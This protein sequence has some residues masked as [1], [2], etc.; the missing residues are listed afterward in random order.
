MDKAPEIQG[1]TFDLDFNLTT[2]GLSVQD[3]A[4]SVLLNNS[5]G[6]QV[7]SIP[8]MFM[9]DS[10]GSPESLEPAR[11]EDIALNLSSQGGLTLTASA[12]ADWLL[13]PARV[14]P[15]TI[16]PT[17]INDRRPNLDTFVQSNISG[18]QSASAELKS[19]YYTGAEGTFTAQSLLKFDLGDIPSGST[20][21]AATLQL[22]ENHSYS[23]NARTVEIRR[24]DGSWGSSVNWSTK[25]PLAANIAASA[26][27]AYG[28]GSSCPGQR[29]NFNVQSVVDYW[30]NTAA[31]NY[32]FGVKAANESDTYGWKKWASD[33]ATHTPWLDVT[34]T[35]VDTTGPGAPAITSTSHALD[36]WSCDTTADFSWS[37][38]SD[39][40][41]IAGY[42]YALDQSSSTSGSS[43]M[44]T[45]NSLSNLNAA[46]P[47]DWWFHV[48]AKD[49]AGNWG[50]SKDHRFKID[51][52]T[53]TYQSLSSTTHSSGVWGPPSGR[54]DFSYSDPESSISNYSYLIDSG[55]TTTDPGNSGQGSSSFM[56]FGPLGTGD[57]TFHVKGK[58]GAGCWSTDI[59]HYGLKIDATNPPAPTVASTSHPVPGTAYNNNDVSLSWSSTDSQSGTVA[60]SYAF[61]QSPTIS[62][63]TQSEGSGTSTTYNDR[64]NGTWYFHVRAKDAVGN[65][66]STRDFQVVINVDDTP[67]SAPGITA[68]SHALD[69]WSCDTTADFTW[70]T[71]SDPSGIA[72]YWYS[73]DQSATTT[74]SP[75]VLTTGNSANNLNAASTGDWWFHV[76]AKDG[77]GNWSSITNHHFKVD[78]T[79][80]TKVNVSSPTHPSGGWGPASGSIDFQ[81]TDP[82]SGIA[83]YS[84]LLDSGVTTTDPGNTSQGA[85]TST[86]FGPLTTGDYTFHVKARNGAGCWSS[87]TQITHYGVKVD[88]TA[89]GTPVVSSSTHPVQGNTY[90]LNDASFSWTA[91]DLHSGVGGYS[92]ELNQSDISTPD[93]T[94]EGAASSKS[95]ADVAD[96]TWWFHVRARDN[97]GNWGPAQHF[98]V[99]IDTPA[100]HLAVAMAGPTTQTGSDGDPIV[101]DGDQLV[102]SGFVSEGVGG[103]PDSTAMV[104]ACDVV[105]LDETASAE[106][107]RLPVPLTNCRNVGGTIVGSVAVGSFSVQNGTAVIEIVAERTIGGVTKSS[108]AVRS[109]PIEIDNTVP[110][111]TDAVLKCGISIDMSCDTSTRARIDFSE[112]V[113]G[114]FGAE[115]FSVTAPNQVLTVTSDC[116][117]ETYCDRAEVV[118]ALPLMGTVTY[119]Y[120]TSTSKLRPKDGA[121]HYLAPASLPV[122]KANGSSACPPA[123]SEPVHPDDA[124]LNLDLPC[125]SAIGGNNPRPAGI[126]VLTI[127]TADGLEPGTRSAKIARR[128]NK[129]RSKSATAGRKDGIA[130]PP[131][132]I[133]LQEADSDDRVAVKHALN[134]E[135]GSVLYRTATGDPAIIDPGASPTCVDDAM[136]TEAILYRARKQGDGKID[137]NGLV[138]TATDSIVTGV[139]INCEGAAVETYVDESGQT[140]LCPKHDRKKHWLA[141]FE[142]PSTGYTF[143]VGSVHFLPTSCL[144]PGWSEDQHDEEVRS[145]SQTIASRLDT[146]GAGKHAL[147][148]GGD[149]SIRRCKAPIQKNEG[150]D[151]T[152]GS[153][154]GN[155]EWWKGMNTSGWTDVIRNLWGT[156]LRHQYLDGN[157]GFTNDTP[158]Y[159][160]KRLD[161]LWTKLATPLRASHDLSCGV[162]ER[163]FEH[164][165]QNSTR[166]ARERYAD[167]RLLWTILNG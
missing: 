40:S 29:V 37:T 131:D 58:N 117:L 64:A 98:S 84:H 25:P 149:F 20:I 136:S 26:N 39:P 57:H 91:T 108:V 161:Y 158:N 133:I 23:C 165:C 55:S 132:V 97:V 144:N 12:D 89:P 31:V 66:G 127:N 111:I 76:R 62:L 41:G 146:F 160:P 138:V 2:V 69:A 118:T 156:D 115:D 44:T 163:D 56:N 157:A 123:I 109:E 128:I 155:R 22:F 13:D 103:N 80:P 24:V 87:G 119:Q 78:T 6:Q 164:N 17:T 60:Y 139:N 46:S 61:D 130:R 38:P 74:A 15:V 71:P 95:Y 3:V 129:L 93:T 67:S 21:N 7:F 73:L 104:T 162:T 113:T 141:S 140:Q 53:P 34:Y 52:T 54:M 43:V 154:E 48:R 49:G 42:W 77:A 166:P 5:L 27:V 68:T 18:G 32:G 135:F 167:H 120:V 86:S 50:T 82:D 19:G 85:A 16:D 137:V 112:P 105:I 124:A 101:K 122:Q 51:T 145:W 63:D 126:A 36:A 8:H 90:G 134:V 30:K 148:M 83:T 59:R 47:G 14:Y 142:V 121:G 96:G 81:Y 159:R 45:G 106:L 9:Y 153:E 114:G 102:I 11:S 116:A 152:K 92:Y 150:K 110:S 1:D 147:V 151:C 35:E 100:P 79:A 94:S 65:W 143:S 10:S 4:D 107:N 125:V 75:S 72:G 70:S 99:S 33:E 88:A 28:Y